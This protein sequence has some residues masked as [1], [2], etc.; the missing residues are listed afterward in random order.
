MHTMAEALP[1]PTLRLDVTDWGKV[2]ENVRRVPG[3]AYYSFATDPQFI[4]LR[5]E[6]LEY[7][8]NLYRNR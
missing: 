1:D 4:A 2:P 3:K 7:A 5:E 6:A 8:A